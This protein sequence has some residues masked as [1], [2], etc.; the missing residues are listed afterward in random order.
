VWWH[1]VFLIKHFKKKLGSK[2]GKM[3]HYTNCLEIATKNPVEFYDITKQILGEISKSKFTFGHVLIQAMHTT[4]GVYV[5]E[6]EERL[7]E[8]FVLQLQKRAP[9]G[10]GY[11]HDDISERK[12]CPPDE[13]KNGHSHMMATLY[14]QPSVS[15]ILDNGALQIGKFQ[16]ILFGEFDGPCPRKHKSKR[17]CLVSIIGE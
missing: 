7:M 2:R 6:G 15:L 17:K 1:I 10:P 5:N 14:S 12:D 16:R 4:T 8:D 9:K 11:L 3:K 13:P